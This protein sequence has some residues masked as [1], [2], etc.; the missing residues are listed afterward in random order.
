MA[1]RVDDDERATDAVGGVGRQRQR[2][3]QLEHDLADVVDGQRVRLVPR[4]GVDVQAVADLGQ[5]RLHPAVAVAHPVLAARC[6]RLGVE[7]A[8][9]G[10]EALRGLQGAGGGQPVAARDVELT[11]E[12]DAGRLPRLRCGHCAASTAQR[13]HHGAFAAGEDLHFVADLDTALRDAAPQHP[14]LVA[15]AIA[16]ARHVLHGQ[17]ES[18]VGALLRGRQ[19]FEQLQ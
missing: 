10:G 9:R 2:L 5:P 17:A 4:Q 11:V 12:H 6:G 7:P 3:L 16:V 18:A 14:R 19:L 8:Q 1:G 15:D 13:G